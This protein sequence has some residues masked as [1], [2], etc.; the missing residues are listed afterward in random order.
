MTPTLR[1]LG[2]KHPWALGRP[3]REVWP[4]IFDIIGPLLKRTHQSGETTGADDAAIFLNRS[5]YVEEFYCSFS[6][7]PLVNHAG[8]I[9]AVFAT[10]PETSERV[11]GERRLRT[12]QKLG[13]DSRGLIDPQQ[14]LSCAREVLG[15][16]PKDIPFA[17]NLLLGIH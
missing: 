6:Y 5:G 15:E 10:I 2:T 8:N 16:N 12:L 7:S 3:A 11:I 13:V 9:E 14:V 1:F 17:A 4:E